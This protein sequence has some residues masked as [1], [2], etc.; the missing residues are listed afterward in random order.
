M[1]NIFQFDNETIWAL[2]EMRMNCYI[3]ITSTE[4]DIKELQKKRDCI[5]VI[6]RTNKDYKSATITETGSS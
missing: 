4:K 3:E 2:E 1:D 6:L 5:L